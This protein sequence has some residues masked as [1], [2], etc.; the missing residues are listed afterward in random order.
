[1]LVRSVTEPKWLITDKVCGGG[2]ADVF[3]GKFSILFVE[4]Y[5]WVCGPSFSISNLNAMVLK[6]L[7][8]SRARLGS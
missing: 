1:M 3:P 6:A 7:D 8:L 5:K 4:V 2:A